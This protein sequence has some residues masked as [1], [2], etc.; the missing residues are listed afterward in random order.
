MSVYGQL[1][2]RNFKCEQ[3][4][5]LKIVKYTDL[6]IEIQNTRT[7]KA[8]KLEHSQNHSEYTPAFNDVKAHV[9]R[10]NNISCTTNYTHRIASTFTLG[11]FFYV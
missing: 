2:F 6:T 1:N 9:Y 4:R 10:E 11:I 5:I 3:E 7:V 8:E